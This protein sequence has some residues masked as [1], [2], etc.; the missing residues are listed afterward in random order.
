[1]TGV[2]CGTI[3]DEDLDTTYTFNSCLPTSG[4]VEVIVCGHGTF[5]TDGANG[6]MELFVL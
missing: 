3:S 6:L 4:K 1:M 2:S 5:S